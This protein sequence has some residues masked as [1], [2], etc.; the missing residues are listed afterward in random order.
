ME[1]SCNMEYRYIGEIKCDNTVM[2][3]PED[4]YFFAIYGIPYMA[5]FL[6]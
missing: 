2:N 3:R 6:Y 5:L 4:A 1:Y